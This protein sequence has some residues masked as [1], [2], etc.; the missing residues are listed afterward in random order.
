MASP[1]PCGGR[2]RA[3][4]RDRSPISQSAQERGRADE[5]RSQNAAP[6]QPKRKPQGDAVLGTIA[7]HVCSEGTDHDS[8]LR[9]TAVAGIRSLHAAITLDETTSSIP[10]RRC[11]TSGVLDCHWSDRGLPCRRLRS[12]RVVRAAAAARQRRSD[13]VVGLSA[14]AIPSPR[15]LARLECDPP[16][17]SDCGDRR[18]PRT[19]RIDA[20]RASPAPACRARGVATTSYWSADATG[21]R[22]TIRVTAH[23]RHRSP[24]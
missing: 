11:G 14:L 7:S 17:S 3:L 1:L 15:R 16:R 21:M 5:E 22:A 13:A 19:S 24:S 23:A 12:I 10:A 8:A 20:D 6:G 4:A 9:L 2:R 18:E